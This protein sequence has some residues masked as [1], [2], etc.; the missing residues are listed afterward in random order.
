MCTLCL[1][2]KRLKEV[3]IAGGAVLEGERGLVMSESDEAAEEGVD[4][5]EEEEEGRDGA[6][7]GRTEVEEGGTD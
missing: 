2:M 1:P 7:R 4:Q 3:S 5:E 6:L